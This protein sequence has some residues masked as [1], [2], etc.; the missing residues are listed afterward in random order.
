MNIDYYSSTASFYILHCYVERYLPMDLSISQL[1]SSKYF[2]W[3]TSKGV[4]EIISNNTE[5]FEIVTIV[6]QCMNPAV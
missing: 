2:R 5:N 6:R 3:P 1:Q 4:L